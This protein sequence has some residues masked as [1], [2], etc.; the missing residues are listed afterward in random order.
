MQKQTNDKHKREKNFFHLFCKTVSE[1]E[2]VVF[3]VFENPNSKNPM[4]QILL[5]TSD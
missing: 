2:T 1:N 4:C 5:H 3:N